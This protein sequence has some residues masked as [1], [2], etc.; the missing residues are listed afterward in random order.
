MPPDLDFYPRRALGLVCGLLG[1]LAALALLVALLR[2]ALAEPVSG[3]TFVRALL[4]LLLLAVLGNFAILTYG[5]WSLRYRLTADRLDLRWA[6]MTHR[7]PLVDVREVLTGAAAREVSRGGARVAGVNWPG[8]HIG[9]GLHPRLGPIFYYS[10]HRRPDQLCYA[11]TPGRVYAISPADAPG[12]AGEVARRR[13]ALAMAAIAPATADEWGFT[14]SPFWRD[15]G[16]QIVMLLAVAINLALFGYLMIAYPRLP[17]L[18]PLHYNIFGVVDRIGFAN[19]IF[20]LPLIALVILGLNFV[21]GVLLHRRESLA[22]YLLFGSTLWVQLLFLFASVRIGLVLFL[23]TACAGNPQPTPTPT[24]L[25]AILRAETR[26]KVDSALLDFLEAYR[27]GGQSGAE[28]FLRQRQLLDAQERLRLVLILNTDDAGATRARLEQLG[29]QVVNAGGRELEIAVPL[30]VIWQLQAQGGGRSLIDEIASMNTILDV[31]VPEILKPTEALAATLDAS[32]DV[33]RTGAAAWHRAGLTGKGVKIGV[34][35]AGFAGYTRLLGTALPANV[36]T[37]SFLSPEDIGGDGEEHGTAVAEIVHAMAPDAELY[38]ANIETA[39][40]WLAAVDWLEEQGVQ[41]ISHSMGNTTSPLDGTGRKAEAINR[42]AARGVV[43]VNSAGNS[44][45]SH[46]AATLD[47]DDAGWHQFAPGQTRLAVSSP[48]SDLHITLNWLDWTNRTIDYDLYLFNEAGAEIA[49]ATNIQRGTKDPV[50][51]IRFQA[52]PRQRYLVGVKAK[53]PSQ[54]VR[55]DLYGWPWS[56]NM[57]RATAE[58]SL[59]NPADAEAAISVGAAAWQDDSPRAYSS[60][61]PTRDGRAKPELAGPTDV[62]VLSDAFQDRGFGG[63][64]AAAPHVAGVVALVLSAYPTYTPAQVKKYLEDNALDLGPRGPDNQ[65]GYGRLRLPEP[66]TPVLAGRPGATAAPTP[67]PGYVIAG[68]FKDDFF[69]QSGLPVGSSEEADRAYQKGE[70]FILAKLPNRPVLSLY[71]AAYGDVTLE[72]RGRRAGGPDGAANGLVFGYTS[73]G[74]YYAFEVV[75]GGGDVPAQY[76]LS[77]YVGGFNLPLT[78]WT[79]SEAVRGG[80]R[81]NQLRVE[82]RGKRLRL[83]LNGAQI[84]VLDGLRIPP[85]K[86]GMLATGL[87][88]PNAQ[89]AFQAFSA[90]P[91]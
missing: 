72:V 23:A 75:P 11:L 43:W 29:V 66:P 67:P 74:S 55:F 9:R 10:A 50:E 53:D 47:P 44:A 77:M 71:A 88:A 86:V 42:L 61:G 34:L 7:I 14:G 79:P 73:P 1:L 17:P 28:A 16:A 22:A 87:D 5:V 6:H 68:A 36:T 49:A 37:K 90:N 91:P 45:T 25:P 35:D 70:Y 2:P 40:Q 62:E 64:S 81:A 27:A 84:A 83:Y 56:V 38:L 48:T 32:Q 59:T 30:P 52:T 65:T 63:T 26:A 19:E 20:S 41:V 69:G 51:V 57:E 76:R 15:R 18:I 4:A 3:T 89:S 82:A 12:F 33:E 85:G 58:G 80:V 13:A 39:G 24:P 8:Y 60:R 46:Y 78:R 54:R 21:A 31:K